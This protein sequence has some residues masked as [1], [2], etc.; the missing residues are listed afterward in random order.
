MA[1]GAFPD[2]HRQHLGMPGMHGT[3]AA[4][5]AL[6][7]A[8]LLITLGTRFDDR[9]TGRLDSFA[10]ARRRS[11]TPTST[12]PRSARTA[13]PTSRSSATCARC[14]ASSSPRVKAE[15]DAGR[16]ADLTG[17]WK[18]VDGWR[19]TYPLGY[20]EPTD[21]IAVAAVRHR[22]ARRDRRPGDDLRRRRRPAPDVGRPVHRVRAPLHLA[23]LRRARDDGLLRAGGDGRE[24]RLPRQDGVVDRR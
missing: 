3:V 11:S 17:W 4:V 19:E 1:R 16:R 12:R 24:G 23:E 15:F 9:V 10:P 20:E 5:T 21:G 7:K 14:C 6:Q 18:Q 2:S 8:D 22:A 13:R